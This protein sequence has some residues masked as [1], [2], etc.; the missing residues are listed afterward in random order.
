MLQRKLEALTRHKVYRRTF[1]LRN[2]QF[3]SYEMLINSGRTPLSPPNFQV[4]KLGCRD[5]AFRLCV[6]LSQFETNAE[7]K[8]LFFKLNFI[9]GFEYPYISV[10]A[11][12]S[13]RFSTN[14]KIYQMF[15]STL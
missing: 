7:K 5:C 3:I 15:I 10:F 1:R 12:V 8:G 2:F 13:S 6:L 9:L 11:Y 4:L 14:S